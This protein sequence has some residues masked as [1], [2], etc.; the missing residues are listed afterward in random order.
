[1][2]ET[3][4][5]LTDSGLVSS[6]NEIL[7]RVTN[8]FSLSLLFIGLDKNPATFFIVCC[9]GRQHIVE[10]FFSISN[11]ILHFSSII[12]F[13]YQS[14]SSTKLNVEISRSPVSITLNSR[15]LSYIESVSF[16]LSSGRNNW[17]VTTGE[18][19]LACS[20]TCI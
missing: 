15:I 9:K 2:R 1:M 20:F 14:V 18:F 12:D 8:L 7:V 11:I 3:R 10:S 6:N 17:V 5:S 4:D 16:I 19:L 13:S